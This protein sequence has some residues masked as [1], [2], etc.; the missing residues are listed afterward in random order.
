[1]IHRLLHRVPSASSLP[2]KLL[3]Y[4]STIALFIG[5]SI[6][7]SMLS[8]MQWIE[9]EVNQHE[10]E[11]SAPFAISLFQQGAK[12]PLKIGLHVQAYYSHELIPEQYGD[13][14]QFPRGFS[15]E[16]VD[17]EAAGILHEIF[18]FKLFEDDS[19]SQHQEIFLYRNEFKLDGKVQPLYLIMP[20]ENVELSDSKWQS[21]NLFV[22]S[23][24]C[25]LFLL[26]GF[27]I[28]KLSRRLV[29]PVEQLSKQLKSPSKHPK[30]TVP[31]Q[32]AT[33]F[34]ELAHSLNDYR[35]QNEMMIKQEQAFARYASHELRTPLTV[36]CGAA[37]LQEQNDSP[38]FQARQR[39]RI[40]RSA[41]DM[42]HT[43][44]ALL[45]LVKQDKGTE[46][47]DFRALQLKE[48]EQVIASLS[49]LAESK[50]I[51]LLLDF[52][53]SP[54]IKPSP[55]VLRMLLSNLISNAIN[56]SDAGEIT[57]CVDKHQI[58][59]T[60]TGRGLNS[61]ENNGIDGH[62]LGLLIVDSLCQRYQWQFSLVDIKPRGCR[63]SL[64][65]PAALA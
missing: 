18:S 40:Q 10:L 25:V 9:D 61:S 3:L 44:D 37:K 64:T 47:H 50:Q 57:I 58:E 29:E 65:F 36:V 31:A 11:A 23:F 55:A 46:S 15:G 27:A 13:L 63:A 34:S 41:H 2:H 38:E 12:Q 48:I 21:I 62:G 20:A 22:L 30:F 14:S 43:V 26:F 8:L 7:I 45:S 56:A 49:L 24:I 54:Q 5:L 4:F 51:A 53:Q 59:I 35:Q 32:S 1:M 42:Q 17:R 28:H 39:D 16:V 33:E 19:L 6:Y 52:K 60:D